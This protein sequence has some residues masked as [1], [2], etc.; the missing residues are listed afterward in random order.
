M[1]GVD[2]VRAIH[3]SHVLKTHSIVLICTKKGGGGRG[4]GKILATIEDGGSTHMV[5]H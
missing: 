4:E 1:A 5:E 3:S 2:V